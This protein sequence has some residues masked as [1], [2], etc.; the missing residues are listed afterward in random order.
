MLRLNPIMS[1]SCLQIEAT[2]PPSPYQR[3]AASRGLSSFLSGVPSFAEP[4]LLP[5]A[6]HRTHT[7]H[8]LSFGCHPPAASIN[9]RI[10]LLS[11][12]VPDDLVN[13]IPHSGYPS[14]SLTAFFLPPSGKAI[15]QQGSL[16]V[17][18]FLSQEDA[19]G[20]QVDSPTRPP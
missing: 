11:P 20:A 4:R 14:H 7:S 17:P 15:Y 3:T 5:T 13:P 12:H 19:K 8:I 16:A 6:P 2:I 9:A 10:K 18:L 1:P